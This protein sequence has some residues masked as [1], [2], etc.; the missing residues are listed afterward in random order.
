MKIDA[1]LFDICKDFIKDN[2]IID[3]VTISE[4]SNDDVYALIEE[5]CNLIGYHE[6]ADIE[7]LFDE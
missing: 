7:D 2:K 1:E 6:E 4:L 5:I 3:E